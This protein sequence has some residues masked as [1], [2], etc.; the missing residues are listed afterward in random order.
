MTWRALSNFM[1]TRPVDANPAPGR[2][3]VAFIKAQYRLDAFVMAR[4]ANVVPRG[5]RIRRWLEP[6]A[7]RPGFHFVE[8]VRG[9]LLK[10][11]FKVCRFT[12]R[13]QERRVKAV[14]LMLQGLSRND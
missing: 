14:Y 3:L 6:I 9:A 13:L 7:E 2:I 8:N 12:C 4:L 1:G 10:S 11:L 5:L